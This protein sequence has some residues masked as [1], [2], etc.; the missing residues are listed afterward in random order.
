MRALEYSFSLAIN[1]KEKTLSKILSLYGNPIDSSSLLRTCRQLL[2]FLSATCKKIK[3]SL[4]ILPAN[5][6]RLFAV[7]LNI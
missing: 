1:F 4:V 6:A 2:P 5:F 7:S 3:G